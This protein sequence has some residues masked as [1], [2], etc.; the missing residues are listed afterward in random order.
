MWSGSRPNVVG[1][2]YRKTSRFDEVRATCLRIVPRA[3]AIAWAT[4]AKR[5][6]HAQVASDGDVLGW[7]Q[8]AAGTD[9]CRAPGGG[10]A[11]SARRLLGAHLPAVYPERWETV[12]GECLGC[13][14]QFAI[15]V[16]LPL[17]ATCPDC[18]A[19]VLADIKGEAQPQLPFVGEPLLAASSPG[20]VPRRS[21]LHELTI[22]G[23]SGCSVPASPTP[24]PIG[25]RRARGQPSLPDLPRCVA[26]R[27]LE[28][29]RPGGADRGAARVHTP[30]R[31]RGRVAGL[32][33][34]PRHRDGRRQLPRPGRRAPGARRGRALRGR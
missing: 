5:G 16:R 11:V 20:V 12:A 19:D 25:G 3:R 22:F 27:R 1:E 2:T 26:R 28:P 33:R 10:G 34:W 17:P 9:E 18:G 23:C 13:R 7:L 6:R 8:S 4:D 32:L 31:G 14:T 21:D 30:E 15:D 29:G 24:L